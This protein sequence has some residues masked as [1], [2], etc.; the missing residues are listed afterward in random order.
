MRD[1]DLTLEVLRQIKEAA[2]KI[3]FRFQ[4]IENVSDFTDSPRGMGK[5]RFHLHDAHRHWGIPEKS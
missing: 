1:K 2:D 5:N 4:P 3:L